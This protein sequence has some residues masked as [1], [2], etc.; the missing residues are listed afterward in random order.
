MYS[1]GC[2][3]QNEVFLSLPNNFIGLYRVY[4]KKVDNFETVLNLAK[5]LEV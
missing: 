4:K 3:Y 1:I 5:W 2:Q